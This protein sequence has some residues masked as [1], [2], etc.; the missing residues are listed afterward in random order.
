[1]KTGPRC[2]LLNLDVDSCRCILFAGKQLLARVVCSLMNSEISH[3]D[4][5]G[6]LQVLHCALHACPASHGANA[7]LAASADGHHLCSSERL[8]TLDVRFPDFHRPRRQRGPLYVV[9]LRLLTAACPCMS[10]LRPFMQLS[11]LGSLVSSAIHV[12]PNKQPDTGAHPQV[13]LWSD[14]QRAL[15]LDAFEAD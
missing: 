15:A 9:M 6:C 2:D 13:L 11:T 12:S 8:D 3:P 7:D 1:M 14:F 4:L 5:C 10:L